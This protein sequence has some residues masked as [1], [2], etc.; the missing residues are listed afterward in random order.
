MPSDLANS[1]LLAM[2]QLPDPNFKRAVVQLI[3]HDDRGTFGL[4]L[5]READLTAGALCESLELPWNGDP[6]ARIHWGGPV[7]VNTGWVLFAE[8]I[9]SPLGEGEAQQVVP[10][11]SFAGSLSVLQAVAEAPPADVRL[12]LGYA[13][14]GPGQLENEIASGAWLFAPPSVEAVFGVEPERMWDYVVRGLGV[15]P[16]TLVSTAG[17]H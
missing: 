15:D 4:V 11:M 13:G 6:D 9:A 8:D 16:A 17:V 10:G 5:N 14:W 1:L 2:P 7:Q 12:F 3:D